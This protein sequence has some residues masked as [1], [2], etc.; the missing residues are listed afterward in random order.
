MPCLLAGNP[1]DTYLV[2]VR[3]EAEM[4]DSLTVALWSTEQNDVGASWCA[5]GQL[6]EGQALPARLL[7]PSTCGCG[8]A[9]GADSHLWN[10][11]EAVVVCDGADYC[12]NL[13]LVCLCRMWVCRYCYNL[14]EGD[15]RLV[16]LACI[17]CQTLVFPIR[18]N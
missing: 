2:R 5:H 11:I 6:V 3:T 14:R 7:D 10:F 16:D 13:A 17:C 9:E 1:D 12:A 18:T 4:L 15:R 8:E